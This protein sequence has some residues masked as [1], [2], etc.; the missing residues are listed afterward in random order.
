MACS[1]LQL[2]EA[3]M[4]PKLKV[5]PKRKYRPRTM[6]PKLEVIPKRKYRPRTM[7]LTSSTYS[8][9]VVLWRLSSSF[10]GFPPRLVF[11]HYFFHF[12]HH[13]C[14]LLPTICGFLPTICG[15]LHLS[16]HTLPHG[17]RKW[18]FSFPLTSALPHREQKPK[19]LHFS[20]YLAF[21]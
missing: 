20:C 15:F 10:G 3:F 13:F 16:R 5:I 6:R 12:S 8:E 14:T 11:S 9:E 19:K 7:R 2:W 21:F 1:P 17:E 4:R 18:L